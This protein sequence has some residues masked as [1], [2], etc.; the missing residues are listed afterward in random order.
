MHSNIKS[1]AQGILIISCC[2]ALI[3][4][5]QPDAYTS[6]DEKVYFKDHQG[7]WIL[8]NY[9]AEWCKPCRS[10]MPELNKVYNDYK[11]KL[12]LFGV[13]FDPM[14]KEKMQQFATYYHLN[15]PLLTS[16]PADYFGYDRNI[17]GLPATYVISP[18][19]QLVKILYGP[20]T[21][22]NLSQL[23]LNNFNQDVA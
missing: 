15:Y 21:A 17:K 19:G 16:N 22:E 5:K 18:Q 13:S 9:W 4:C 12:T 3:A 20:Q 1:F 7:K 11:D 14:P 6:S 10:E 8:I 2:L 23:V